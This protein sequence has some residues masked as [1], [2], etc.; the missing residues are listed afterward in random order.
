MCECDNCKCIAECYK[1]CPCNGVKCIKEKC[2]T[3]C[4]ATCTC[5]CKTADRGRD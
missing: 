2:N 4:C 1:T 5:V 3:E